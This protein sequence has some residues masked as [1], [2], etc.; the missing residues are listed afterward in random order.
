MSHIRYM[1][2]IK[3]NARYKNSKFSLIKGQIDRITGRHTT[4]YKVYINR[5]QLLLYFSHRNYSATCD[6]DNQIEKKSPARTKESKI[7]GSSN[8]PHINDI[9]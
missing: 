7:I 6:N 9:N 2:N 1:I 8:V 3:Y 5:I 4:P